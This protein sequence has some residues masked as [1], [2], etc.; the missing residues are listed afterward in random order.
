VLIQTRDLPLLP[1]RSGENGFIF[2]RIVSGALFQEVF[3][4]A[5]ATRA[6][7]I[8]RANDNS[9]HYLGMLRLGMLRIRSGSAED[10]QD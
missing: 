2:N 7:K 4:R 8:Q 3:L 9:R 10:K 5:S 6:G 1:S